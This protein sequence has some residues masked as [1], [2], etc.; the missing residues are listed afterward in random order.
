M[1]VSPS[2]LWC[3]GGAV[4]DRKLRLLGDARMGSS[5]PVREAATP[6]GVARN[7][8]HNLRQLG[9]AVEL[10]S[11]W[12]D[13][14]AGRALRASCRELGIGLHAAWNYTQGSVYSGIVSGNAPANG[15]FKST[16]EGPDWLTGGSFGV[17]ASVVAFLICASV[18]IWILIAAKRRG[19]IIAPAWKRSA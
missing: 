10:L 1:R 5:N 7:V 19:H 11:V 13:D 16:L 6:G 12:G 14:A 9:F 3:L 15:Y 17:E 8:A 2:A 18:G 4:W